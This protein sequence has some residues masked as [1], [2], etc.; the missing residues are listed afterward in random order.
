MS[1]ISC[2]LLNLF[3]NDVKLKMKG[4]ATLKM[5]NFIKLFFSKCK[6][7]KHILRTAK[8]IGGRIQSKPGKILIMGLSNT[9]WAAAPREI[10]SCKT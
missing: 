9:F 10:K 4:S 5:R 6:N 2:I 8:N 7:L 3:G 1:P